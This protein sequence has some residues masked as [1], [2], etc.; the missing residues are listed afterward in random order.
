MRY[1]IIWIIWL[2]RQHVV[3]YPWWFSDN[4]GQKRWDL[5]SD[6]SKTSNR[7]PPTLNKVEF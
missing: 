6:N 7:S 2:I 5:S 1:L 3:F 4:G